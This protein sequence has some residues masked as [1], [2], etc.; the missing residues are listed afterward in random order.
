M[1]D[2]KGV[3]SKT[4]TQKQLDDYANQHNPNNKAYYA[5]IA[6]EK[7]HK[8]AVIKKEAR[9]LAELYDDLG[10]NANLDWMC[11]SNPYDCS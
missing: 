4:H 3:S 1:A 11:Y 9:H 7:K 5:R 10:L 2:N 6:N 8:K